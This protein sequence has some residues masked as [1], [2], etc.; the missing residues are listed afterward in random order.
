MLHIPG[1]QHDCVAAK[2]TLGNCLKQL[3][4]KVRACCRKIAF[5]IKHTGTSSDLTE[6]KQVE[7]H[8]TVA[9]LCWFLFDRL[10]LNVYGE[11]EGQQESVCGV[12]DIEV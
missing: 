3:I 7:Q 8:S 2:Y 4:E 12:V 1:I 5:S 9:F 11:G 6:L 10:C